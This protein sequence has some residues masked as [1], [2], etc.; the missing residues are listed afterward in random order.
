MSTTATRK[1]EN[2][3]ENRQE[4]NPLQPVDDMMDY[5]RNYAREEPEIMACVCLG[6]GFI[7]GWRLKPW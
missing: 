2:P 6:I 4:H 7:L 5:L 1:R 3:S